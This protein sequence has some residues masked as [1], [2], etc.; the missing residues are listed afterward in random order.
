[1]SVDATGYPNE[2]F[3]EY[4][5]FVRNYTLDVTGGDLQTL[6]NNNLTDEYGNTIGIELLGN[7]EGIFRNISN[8]HVHGIQYSEGFVT[9]YGAWSYLNVSSNT[10]ADF[11]THWNYIDVC[12]SASSNFPLTDM[13]IESL[14]QEFESVTGYDLNSIE[15]AYNSTSGRCN[16][17]YTGANGEI[18]TAEY[19]DSQISIQLDNSQVYAGAYWTISSLDNGENG[20]SEAYNYQDGTQVFYYNYPTSPSVIITSP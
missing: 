1:M 11:Y 6:F 14:N 10:Q 8:G 3:R 5:D 15:F 12:S 7:G 20:W 13:A 19:H 4:I 2:V 16:Y 9:G 18:I 17:S